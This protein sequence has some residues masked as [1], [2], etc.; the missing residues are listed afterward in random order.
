[1]TYLRFELKLA[2]LAPVAACLGIALVAGK[3]DAATASPATQL[4]RPCTPVFLK[5]DA[6]KSSKVWAV[7]IRA[8]ETNC[9]KARFIAKRRGVEEAGGNLVPSLLG[10]ASGTDAAR[11]N[12][13]SGGRLPSLTLTSSRRTSSSR[14]L[15]DLRG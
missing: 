10:T 12:A 15:D 13:R 4:A 3:P 5:W 9:K 14:R 1:M 6:K 7:G 8:R 2:A 11:A